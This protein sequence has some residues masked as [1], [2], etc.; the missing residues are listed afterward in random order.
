MFYNV[1]AYNSNILNVWA[2]NPSDVQRYVNWLNRNREINLYSAREADT[3]EWLALE[4]NTE[5]LNCDEP[6]WDDFM[7]EESH[8]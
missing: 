7:D 8:D 5:V 1:T 6:H 4:K 3:A 2:S